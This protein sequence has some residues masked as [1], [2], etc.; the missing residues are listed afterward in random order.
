MTITDCIVVKK[1]SH[2]GRRHAYL[3]EKDI[4]SEFW[5]GSTE[6]KHDDKEKESSDWEKGDCN[7]L[8]PVASGTVD[9]GEGVRVDWWSI[10]SHTATTKLAL[11][12]V[13]MTQKHI[14]F[15]GTIDGDVK[16][17]LV[18]LSAACVQTRPNE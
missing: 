3:Y 1:R 7:V 5:G 10:A 18:F 11:S 14:D 17:V 12:E 9:T 2:V 8:G 4:S 16:K 13:F 6:S 15:R